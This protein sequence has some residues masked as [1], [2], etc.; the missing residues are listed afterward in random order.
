MEWCD[1]ARRAFYLR[2]HFIVGK[3]WEMI[4]RPAEIG[5]IF[6]ASQTFIRY[7]FRSSN[8]GKDLQNSSN[9]HT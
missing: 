5:R 9:G 2:P 1:R 7:L 8:S 6:K 4:S 3:V